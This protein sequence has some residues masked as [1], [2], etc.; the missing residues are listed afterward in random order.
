MRRGRWGIAVTLSIGLVSMGNAD[1]KLSP[2]PASPLL[3]PLNGVPPAGNEVIIP[4]RTILLNLSGARFAEGRP[5]RIDTHSVLSWEGFQGGRIGDW[6]FRISPDASAAFSRDKRLDR[7]RILVS[8]KAYSGCTAAFPSGARVNFD[9][10]AQ[11]NSGEAGAGIVS[12]YVRW[13]GEQAP[14]IKKLRDQRLKDD[15]LGSD[16]PRAENMPVLAP[17]GN[18]R[19]LRQGAGKAGNQRLRQL[20]TYLTR[21][22]FYN[23]AVDGVLGPRTRSAIRKAER[24]ES[25]PETGL[26]SEGLWRRIESRTPAQKTMYTVPAPLL[27]QSASLSKERPD[28]RNR[29][30]FLSRL[31]CNLSLS[32]VRKYYDSKTSRYKSWK[33]S[34]A[35]YCNV[36]LTEK[37]TAA[38]T[39]V[40]FPFAQQQQ[41]WDPDFTYAVSYKLS[42]L[43]SIGFDNYSGNRMPWSNRKGSGGLR[44][45]GFQLSTEIPKDGFARDWLPEWLSSRTSCGVSARLGISY[46]DQNDGTQYGKI[47]VGASCGFE[48]LRNVT[49]RLGVTTYPLAGQQQPWDSDLNYQFGYRISDQWSFEFNGS[50]NF[51]WRKEEG[52]GR[53]IS[54]SAFRLS[55]RLEL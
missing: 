44:S 7:Q 51:P 29:Q 37:L 36:A 32:S 18:N 11:S 35:L 17:Q 50:A 12:D 22:G 43:T 8:C 1:D 16:V 53:G 42:K 5:W 23:G 10:E 4:K 54:L 2:A 6:Y 14:I 13:V 55:Y 31:R 15:V 26:P 33:T 21:N 9:P 49:L 46:E 52:S 3:A 19:D 30:D 41:P 38:G 40:G 48:P 47:S 28:E 39:L 25:L 20:Q 34:G 27:I 24:A 45:G